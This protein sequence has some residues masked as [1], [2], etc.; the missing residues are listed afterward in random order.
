MPHDPQVTENVMESAF[1][2]TRAE[3]RWGTEGSN[4]P[5]LPHPA[6]RR[7]RSFLQAGDAPRLHWEKLCS[8]HLQ[9]QVFALK[10][11]PLPEMGTQ[12]LV[13]IRAIWLLGCT[14]LPGAAGGQLGERAAPKPCPLLYTSHP[15]TPGCSTRLQRDP[16]HSRTVS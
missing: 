4:R 15:D 13:E 8:L 1:L 10:I 14:C 12:S 11:L 5:A 9:N 6:R 2:Q 16:D 7:G 3:T